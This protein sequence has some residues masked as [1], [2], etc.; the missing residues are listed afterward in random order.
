MINIKDRKL[1][2]LRYKKDNKNN[3]ISP[4]ENN[5]GLLIKY[6]V[7]KQNYNYHYIYTKSYYLSDKYM[8]Y[9]YKKF[10]SYDDKSVDYVKKI[11]YNIKRENINKMTKITILSID[12]D[13][14]MIKT[15]SNY[16]IEKPF[17]NYL[18]KNVST[19]LIPLR[20]YLELC[21]NYK[22]ALKIESNQRTVYIKNNQIVTDS[23]DTKELDVKILS[24][25][26]VVSEMEKDISVFIQPIILSI[27]F[28]IN[29][30]I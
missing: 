20:E 25:S 6:N 30:L 4:I 29:L 5:M 2:N 23:I 11:V 9:V 14:S 13:K 26:F 3:E 8:S 15:K 10:Y 27:I 28:I 16:P 19:E 24:N 1:G 18:C 7:N 22:N 17:D 21:E 12:Y